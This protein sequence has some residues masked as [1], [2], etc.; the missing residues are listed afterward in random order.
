LDSAPP[1]RDCLHCGVATRAGCVAGFIRDEAGRDLGCPQL[2]DKLRRDSAPSIAKEAPRYDGAFLDERIKEHEA[3]LEHLRLC[4]AGDDPNR[5][6]GG[7]II[8][9]GG[10]G[11]GKT[12][13]AYAAVEEIKKWGK[14]GLVIPAPDLLEEIKATYNDEAR[15]CESEILDECRETDLLALDDFG[16]Q[17]DSDWSW[18]IFYKIINER[19]RALRPSI[20]T[21][22]ETIPSLMAMPSA[23][24]IMSRLLDSGTVIRFGKGRRSA[25]RM[26][27]KE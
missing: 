1:A 21:T 27:T 3:I 16:K 4:H 20:I 23:G 17:R 8:L 12:Y 6:S 19:Y 13:A 2:L 15:C 26:V 22:N 10:Y 5:F 14:R 9:L 11:S 18:E 24:A 25:P 7:S